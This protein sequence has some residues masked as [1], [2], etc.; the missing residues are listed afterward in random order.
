M[1]LTQARALY[2]DVDHAES[3]P[4]RDLKAMMALGRW[5]MRFSPVVALD[6]VLDK[7]QR[8]TPPT[9]LLLDVTGCER[10]FHGLDNLIRQASDAL[11]RIG[12]TARLAIA[13]TPGAAWALALG[14]E[15]E[16]AIV[17]QEDLESA[18]APLP[19]ASLRIGEELAAALHH[20]GLAT[21][22]QLMQLPRDLLPSRFGPLLLERLDQALGRIPEP[23]VPLEHRTPVGA[24]MEFDGAVSSLEAIWSIFQ[25]LI[26]RVIAQLVHRGCGARQLDIELLRNYAPPL[27]KTI[28]LSRAS[29]DSVNLFNL[30]RCALEDVQPPRRSRLRG[31]PP[32]PPIPPRSPA[33]ASVR[34]IKTVDDGF[35]GLVLSVPNYEPL[36]DEQI[37][38]LE[39][40]QYAGQIELDRLIERLRVRLGGEAIVQAE[41][42]ESYVPELAW[43]HDAGEAGAKAELL[44]PR[45]RSSAAGTTLA[46]KRK[47][48]AAPLRSLPTPPAPS[49]R[50]LHL[51][52][53]PAE[54]RVMVSPSHD[55][56]GRPVAFTHENEVRRV[57]HAAGPERIGGRWW[58]GHD[59][60]RDYFD[61]ED[62]FGR[63]FW[64][65]RVA[66]SG[67]WFLHGVFE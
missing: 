41:L 14:C 19:S 44:A 33:S 7:D 66:Q 18:L 37:S 8:A 67:K 10:L 60:T 23:L 56:E 62:P 24:R 4:Q 63:R 30:F 35:T 20:L 47:K 55:Q 16:G 9:S 17:G 1:T 29:R 5:M 6:C 27:R 12:I 42:V 51:L 25:Q 22:G 13:P 61:V 15:Q 26:G 21:V 58:D 34:L 57:L 46:R 65:F 64:I 49:T 48:I 38:L 45:G 32:R 50:P 52:R 2:A 53:P 11:S 39:H 43:R 31:R 54:V 3:E 40:E 59:K 36:A 28:H